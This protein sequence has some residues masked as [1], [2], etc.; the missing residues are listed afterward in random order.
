MWSFEGIDEPTI[1]KAEHLPIARALGILSLLPLAKPEDPRK[2]L[3]RLMLENWTPAL[4]ISNN[5][6]REHP[7]PQVYW[8]SEPAAAVFR[9]LR[10][11]VRFDAT[12]ATLWKTVEVSGHVVIQA[13][14][15]RRAVLLLSLIERPAVPESWETGTRDE[16]YQSTVATAIPIAV[17]Q[18]FDEAS[19]RWI[20]GGEAAKAVERPILKFPSRQE[21]MA[22]RI[23][24]PA[25]N[26]VPVP[27]VGGGRTRTLTQLHDAAPDTSGSTDVGSSGV[28]GK[29]TRFAGRPALLRTAIAKEHDRRCAAGVAERGIGKEAKALVAWAREEYP[30]ADLPS[31]PRTVENAIRNR[32]NEY[33]KDIA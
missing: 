4:L 23:G 18:A 15:L 30:D 10:V 11:T 29:E 3:R 28:S 26:P 27:K 25:V 24:W 13:A 16:L 22:R 8:Q 31:T 5:A 21:A 6:G 7:I 17:A 20:A 12:A 2:L 19:R 14:L 33:L 32:H 9:Q 1:V